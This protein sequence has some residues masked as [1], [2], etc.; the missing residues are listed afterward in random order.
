MSHALLSRSFCVLAPVC[1]VVKQSFVCWILARPSVLSLDI[2]ASWKCS[3][4]TP[5]PGRWATL[6][7]QFHKHGVFPDC[8][9]ESHSLRVCCLLTCPFLF[10]F[11]PVSPS[12]SLPSPAMT[13]V[14]PSYHFFRDS[15]SDFNDS[16]SPL[17]TPILPTHGSMYHF[18]MAPTAVWAS[19]ISAFCSPL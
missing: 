3:P 10:F 9:T 14:F 4:T 13:P 17:P 18:F 6:S 7:F 5:P 1:A 19:V 15:F 11:A 2:T 12:F 8:N 16:D